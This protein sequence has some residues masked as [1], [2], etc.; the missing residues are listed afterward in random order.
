MD[1]GIKRRMSLKIIKLELKKNI[2]K[3]EFIKNVGF[4]SEAILDFSIKDNKLIVEI[5]D[6]A[7]ENQIEHDLK[8]YAEKFI[9]SEE[10]KILYNYD[11]ST[12]IYHD[13]FNKYT[14][15]IHDFGC[16]NVVF[17]GV[18]EF[19]YR[20]FDRRF[21]S[22]AMKHNAYCKVY[23]TLL[24]I[25]A[26][27]KTGYL[28][29]S[30]QYAI[31][32]C[33]TFEDMNKL[34]K[35]DKNIDSYNWSSVLKNPTHALSPSACFHTYLEYENMVLDTNSVVTF[36]Q[37]VFRNEGR[38]NYSEFG[39]LM[40]Y[41]V[42]EIVMIGSADFVSNMRKRILD[43]VIN[44]LKQWEMCSKVC[45][46]ADP[47][48]IPKMQKFKKIQKSEELK[49]EVRLNCSNEHEIS[50]ASFNLHGTAFTS[51]FNIK[52]ADTENTVTGCIGFGLERWVIAFISQFGID[53]N[54]WPAEIK[55][56]Y[57]RE[58]NDE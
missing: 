53:I 6:N 52:I 21:E 44:L 55:N 34:E 54:D 46:A 45:V 5:S 32:C 24:P 16:G 56:A 51:P 9:F 57:K 8:L 25:E 4:V 27:K 30:P 47:F 2:D 43:E 10:D 37:N 42:R 41:H 3:K 1:E 15:C 13:V 22:I 18:A 19:L 39:R 50:V 20:F 38:F 29:H 35:L 33:S 36:N 12:R 28:K 7:D 23:P 31:F 17:S 58:Q 26:Y 14:Q 48:I 49:Y 40:G 11:D